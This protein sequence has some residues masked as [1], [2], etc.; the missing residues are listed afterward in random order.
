[1]KL[2]PPPFEE[3]TNYK[4]EKVKRSFLDI[5]LRPFNLYFYHRMMRTAR[6]TAKSGR[7]GVLDAS[8]LPTHAWETM[9]GVELCGGEIITE[10]LENV[11]GE[12]KN[13]VIFIGNHMSSLE[14]MSLPVFL[15]PQHV[16][17][18]VKESLFDY[19]FFGDIMRGLR[20]IPMTRTNPAADLKRLFKDGKQHI[21]EGTSVIVFP[22]KTRGVEFVEEEFNSI[23]I[24]L[25]RRE[26][27]P[28]IPI[29]LKTDLWG[30]GKKISDYGPVD[31]SQKVRFA[32]GKPMEVTKENEQEA[33][34]YCLKFIGDKLKEW[35]A[36][37]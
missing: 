22:Q 14:T 20:C 31:R 1:M 33:H 36:E 19:P 5:I 6:H 9:E 8:T 23:G 35:E 21:S 16:T 30:L 34:E 2:T 15:R 32:V 25:A 10:G 18:V 17:F 7:D 26:K 37:G 24:K 4:T 3:R 29:A 28:I 12:A 27:V 11:P 13:P